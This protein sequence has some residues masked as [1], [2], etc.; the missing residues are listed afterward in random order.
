MTVHVVADTESR[1][2]ALRGPVKC[3]TVEDGTHLSVTLR[4]RASCL[5][6]GPVAK[7]QLLVSSATPG[8]AMAS[9][10]PTANSVLGRALQSC[11]TGPNMIDM[12]IA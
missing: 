7:G 5:V 1:T 4:G 11:G 12:V 2:A 8:R 9:N 10:S 3:N 6:I